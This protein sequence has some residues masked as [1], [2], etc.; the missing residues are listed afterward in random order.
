MSIIGVIGGSGLYEMKGFKVLD[1]QLVKTP[2]GEPSA[3]YAIAEYEGQRIAF[4]P[5]H[6]LMHNIHPHK[7][8]YRANIWGFSE[9]GVKRIISVCATGGMKEGMKPGDI[10]LVDQ[11]LDFT[12]G[13]RVGTFY[14]EDKV[15]HVDF[16]EPYCPELRSAILRGADIA[17]VD[18]IDNGTYVCVNGPRLES[19]AEIDF[20]RQSGGHVVGM[21]GMPEASLARELEI[22]YSTIAV[23]TN[24]AAG[25][26]GDKLTTTEVVDTMNKA[27]DKLK[28]I[29]S[30]SLSEIPHERHCHCRDAL[31]DSE[32]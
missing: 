11:V 17:G 25:I 13:A 28:K 12:Q 18:V 16:T 26:T 19:R 7:L 2:F 3:P 32:L 1:E 27:G 5:R 23:V 4:L 10:V 6:G 21:T 24:H 9:I 29:I 30:S 15:V 14:E 8:N 20:F 22:C 31:K